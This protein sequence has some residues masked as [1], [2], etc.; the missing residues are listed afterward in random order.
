MHYPQFYVVTFLSFLVAVY[1]TLKLVRETNYEKY[2]VFFLLS[3]FFMGVHLLVGVPYL[4]GL[5]DEH[6][7]K[8]IEDSAAVLGSLSLAYAAYGLSKTMRA[9]RERFPKE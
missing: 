3:A 8:I 9:I 1:Y 5:I 2:W 7:L 6:A 4:F